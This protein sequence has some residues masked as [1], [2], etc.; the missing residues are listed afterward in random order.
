MSGDLTQFLVYAVRSH[1]LRHT[2]NEKDNNDYDYYRLALYTGYC[3]LFFSPRYSCS[4]SSS[5]DSY[6]LRHGSLCALAFILF[7]LHLRLLSEECGDHKKKNIAR[8]DMIDSQSP[9]PIGM[10]RLM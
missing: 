5:T 4:S 1:S 8:P 9:S 7:D 2:H 10:Q 3:L 6:R